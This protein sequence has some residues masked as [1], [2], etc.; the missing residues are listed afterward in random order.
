M[1]TGFVFDTN[2]RFSLVLGLLGWFTPSLDWFRLGFCG[3]I[4]LFLGILLG[5]FGRCLSLLWNWLFI[6]AI[7]GIWF[8][9]DVTPLLWRRLARA[10]ILAFFS[11]LSFLLSL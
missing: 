11:G 3:T 5:L 6:F 1:F 9:F 7:S 4:G 2:G 10:G 8:V